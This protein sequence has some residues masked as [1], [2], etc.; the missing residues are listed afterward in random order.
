[1][2]LII[3]I[4]IKG[5]LP[6]LPKRTVTATL[7]PMSTLEDLPRELIQLVL[8]FLSWQGSGAAACSC[9]HVASFAR[10]RATLPYFLPAIHAPEA[11]GEEG[12]EAEDAGE[13]GGAEGAAG[14]EDRSPSSLP[15]GFGFNTMHRIA[16]WPVRFEMQC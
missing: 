15:A 11:D 7:R 1:M 13:A 14:T 4:I 3:I 12:T 2:K 5:D 8:S 10:R 16:A 9:S 6:K